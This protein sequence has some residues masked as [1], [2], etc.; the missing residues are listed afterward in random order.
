[1]AKSPTPRNRTTGLVVPPYDGD[2]KAQREYLAQRRSERLA[3]EDLKKT[4][5]DLE[6]ML[7][8]MDDRNEEFR[9]LV[10]MLAKHGAAHASV[11]ALM[12]KLVKRIEDGEM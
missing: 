4:L 1:M 5:A 7:Q 2:K 12:S 10:A 8:A 6:A 11:Q 3:R 9:A